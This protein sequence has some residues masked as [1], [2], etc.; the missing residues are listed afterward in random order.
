MQ[1]YLFQHYL[2][3]DFSFD[4]FYKDMA[5]SQRHAD[6]IFKEMLGKTPKEYYKLLKL[7]HSAEKLKS[8]SIL[9]TAINSYYD[10]SEGYSKAFYKAFGKLPSEYKKGSS[11]IPLFTYYPI[12]PCYEHILESDKEM[13]K[14]SYCIVT[15]VVKEKRKLIFMRSKKATEYFSFCEEIGC[16]WEGLLN[17]N[18]S[19]L[20]TAALLDLPNFLLNNDYGKIACG[21]EVHIDYTGEIPYGYEIA[22]LPPCEMLYFQ[23]QK[24]ANEN[25]YSE[26]INIVLDTAE[27]FDYESYGYKVDNTLAPIFNF[28]AQTDKGARYAVPIRKMR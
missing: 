15:P 11:F 16:D 3:D 17:S 27:N 28:G 13:K 10:T 20:D 7:T 23:S 8:N 4:K 25:D 6:R 5:F 22:E 12:K 19:K 18:S 9:Y 1:E 14:S 21:I 2:D 24:Y 26:M